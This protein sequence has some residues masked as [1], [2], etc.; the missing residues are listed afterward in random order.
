MVFLQDN[1]VGAIAGFVKIHMDNRILA[2]NPSFRARSRALAFLRSL[3]RYL[4]HI[5]WCSNENA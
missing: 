3:Q 5:L 1:W 4:R 2:D